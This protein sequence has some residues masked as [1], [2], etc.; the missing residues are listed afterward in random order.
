[1]RWTNR[2]TRILTMDATSTIHTITI[3][4]IKL[5]LHNNFHSNRID[6]VQ[7]TKQLSHQHRLSPSFY[8]CPWTWVGVHVANLNHTHI[9]SQCDPA[10]PTVPFHLTRSFFLRRWI[11]LKVKAFAVCLHFGFDLVWNSIH[12]DLGFS[13]DGGG[14]RENGCEFGLVWFYV[15]TAFHSVPLRIQLSVS[16]YLYL[17]CAHTSICCF[18][19]EFIVI[20]WHKERFII[21]WPPHKNFTHSNSVCVRPCLPFSAQSIRFPDLSNWTIASQ[22]PPIHTAFVHGCNIKVYWMPCIRKVRHP[23]LR[24]WTLSPCVYS[25]CLAGPVSHAN[26]MYIYIFMRRVAAKIKAVEC[27]PSKNRSLS[28]WRW[29]ESSIE[30]M[31]VTPKI[32][33]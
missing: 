4:A 33:I 3:G 7:H 21:L 14:E 1:M 24:L 10:S 11:A 27:V 32:S 28:N 9:F 17:A 22:T 26:T 2:R 31:Y 5:Q 19:N 29:L 8:F 15:D 18:I 6:V 23:M 12:F 30:V 16:I 25:K 13:R 20:C